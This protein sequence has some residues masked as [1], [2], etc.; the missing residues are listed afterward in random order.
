MPLITFSV[1]DKLA[2]MAIRGSTAPG[3]LQLGFSKIEMNKTSS[4][5]KFFWKPPLYATKVDL[6]SG[7]FRNQEKNSANV[8]NLK[9][10]GSLFQK[11]FPSR[12]LSRWFT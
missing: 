6:K 8:N 5:G 11:L 12:T 9:E 4:G 1:A 2:Q 10:L 7:P 3:A